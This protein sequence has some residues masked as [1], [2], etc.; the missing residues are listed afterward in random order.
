MKEPGDFR[1][2]EGLALDHSSPM[3][4][5]ILYRVLLGGFET[6]QLSRRETC[7]TDIFSNAAISCRVKSRSTRNVLNF[8][9]NP[10][11]SSFPIVINTLMVKTHHVKHFLLFFSIFL[12]LNITIKNKKLL[13][14][15]CRKEN[16][17]WQAKWRSASM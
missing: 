9:N 12:F 8:F 15:K 10:Y 1:H 6:L 17:L 13:A 4:F 7:D 5:L 2:G 14:F 16:Q 3:S 11:I